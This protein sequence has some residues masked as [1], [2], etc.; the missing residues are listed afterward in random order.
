MRWVRERATTNTSKATSALQRHPYEPAY[1]FESGILPLQGYGLRGVLWYQGES[2]ADNV[3]VHERLFPLL[4]KS[5]RKFFGR[6]DP[7]ASCNSRQSAHALRG[8]TSATA[9]AACPKPC[10][11]PTWQ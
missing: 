4:E 11:T 8:H 1:L 5:W 6:T 9:S 3:E 10:P 2:N 7:F